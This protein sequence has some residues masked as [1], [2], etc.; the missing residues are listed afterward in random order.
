MR[1]PVPNEK[2][3]PFPFIVRLRPD[4][5]YRKADRLAGVFDSLGLRVAVLYDPETSSYFVRFVGKK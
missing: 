4:D 1:T 3:A 5:D 2:R